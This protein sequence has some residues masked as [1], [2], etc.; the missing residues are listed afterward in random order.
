MRGDNET[1][2]NRRLVL[3]LMQVLPAVKFT[4]SSTETYLSIGPDDVGH[5]SMPVRANATLEVCI[6][7]NWSSL[8]MWF[9]SQQACGTSHLLTYMSYRHREV[10]HASG[11]PIVAPLRLSH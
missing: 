6:G 4:E 9:T 1:D 8:G 10:R 11:V 2:P 7:H 5:L 3:H